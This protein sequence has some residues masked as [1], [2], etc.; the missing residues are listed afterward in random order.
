MA[1]GK[2]TEEDLEEVRDRKVWDYRRLVTFTHLILCKKDHDE[3]CMFEQE[4]SI[5]GTWKLDAHLEWCGIVDD[6]LAKWN[7]SVAVALHA[8]EEDVSI[9]CHHVEFISSNFAVEVLARLWGAELPRAGT[10]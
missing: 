2:I 9:I 8:M 10:F 7:E 3:E 1:A 4:E 6:L 5:V